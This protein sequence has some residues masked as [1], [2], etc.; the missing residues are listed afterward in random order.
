MG[1]I[2]GLVVGKQVGILLF[3][4]LAVRFSGSGMLPGVTWPQIWGASC[5][6][7]IG[8]TMS[9]FVS[10]LAFNDPELVTEA[11]IGILVASVVAGVLGY[12]ILQRT[13]P[14]AA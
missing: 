12:L 6:A 7:G 9:L 5:L 10:E 4:W 11:K 2:L 1:I 8:F 3:T 13:L 14:K